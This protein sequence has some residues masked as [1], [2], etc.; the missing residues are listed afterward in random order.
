VYQLV[1]QVFRTTEL[2]SKQVCKKID[3]STKFPTPC[4]QVNAQKPAYGE[5][6]CLP[7]LCR[8]FDVDT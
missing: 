8:D 5:L 6:G 4:Y 1:I 7:V 2:L 3:Y